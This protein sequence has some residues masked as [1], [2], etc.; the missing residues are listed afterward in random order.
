MIGFIYNMLGLY[1]EAIDAFDTAIEI[2]PQTAGYWYNK[3]LAL[4]Y[5]G[6]YD[7]ALEAF[8][9]AHELDPTYEI[10]DMP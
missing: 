10:P 6:M 8:E 7:E 3:G 1:E 9:K 2:D 4:K 5:L